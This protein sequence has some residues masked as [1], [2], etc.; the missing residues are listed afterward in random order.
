MAFSTRKAGIP[1]KTKLGTNADL[2]GQAANFS[3][4]YI[5]DADGTKTDITEPFTEDEN[6]AGLYMVE[7]TIPEVGEY[8]V[9]INNSAI[10]MGNHEHALV[11]T[12][13]SIDDVKEAVDA[14]QGDITSIKAVTDLLNTDE[15]EGISEQIT[16][17]QTALTDLTTIV[18]SADSQDSIT[19]IRELLNDIQAG[20]VNVD[21]LLNG[22]KD[23][24]A[25]LNGDEFLSDGETANPTKDKGLVEIFDS[26][27]PI[28][29]DVQSAITTAKDAI[30]A[31]TNAARDTI[32]EKTDAIQ[33]VVDANKATLE[34]AGFGL[35][36]LKT[37]IDD[38]QT[39]VSAGE[40][41]IVDLLSDATNG[42]AAI[43][44]ELV[45]R[46][47]SVDSQLAAIDGKVEAGNHAQAYRVFV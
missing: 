2:S 15:L 22:Q 13:A 21:A 7:T 3:A 47:D 23:V 30:V 20:G 27:A 32:I 10:G 1:F 26:I 8:T 38:V 11:I 45:S 43:K 9:V 40:T 6:T 19:S 46:F 4:Y 36:A 42:L 31:N 14:A 33:T 25:M 44:S 37:L 35:S 17:A 24:E 28:L 34:D 29:G 39:S 16:A 18:D 5:N 12:A 41:N